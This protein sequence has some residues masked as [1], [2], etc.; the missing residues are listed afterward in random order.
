MQVDVRPRSVPAQWYSTERYRVHDREYELIGTSQD[1]EAWTEDT[2]SGSIMQ[3]V[4]MLLPFPEP[5]YA[6]EGF[7]VRTTYTAITG[8][9]TCYCEAFATD[10]FEYS[11]Q[12]WRYWS[13]ER[14]DSGA[15][16][17]FRSPESEDADNRTDLLRYRPDV[18][19]MWVVLSA[20]LYDRLVVEGTELLWS[21]Y[22][23]SV[24][25]QPQPKVSDVSLYPNPA[26]D[27]LVVR[28]ATGR[29]EVFDILGRK[30]LYGD[31]DGEISTAALS[32]GRYML[33]LPEQR[34]SVPFVRVK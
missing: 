3:V 8:A 5:L 16:T 20:G 13:S 21:D 27:V 31:L 18:A 2:D 10:L 33:V 26:V 14:T 11:S 9:A 22:P 25:E 32:S 34:T 12:Y 4:V 19:G 6:G 1:M 24:G 30:V 7:G 23:L 28:G 17:T 15:V 29:Y